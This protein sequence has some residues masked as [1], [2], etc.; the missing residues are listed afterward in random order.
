MSDIFKDYGYGIADCTGELRDISGIVTELEEIQSNF[1]TH[2][3][4]DYQLFLPGKAE[5]LEEVI[6]Y[7]KRV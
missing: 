7:L 5:M 2:A 3:M 4:S 6:E 1:S